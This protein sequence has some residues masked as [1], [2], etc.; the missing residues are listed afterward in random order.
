MGSIL[1]LSGSGEHR[2]H[3][4]LGL[5]AGDAG[6]RHLAGRR[7]ARRLPD[8]HLPE[9]VRQR[10][11]S[12]PRW[13][14]PDC[15][16]VHLP[17]KVRGTLAGARARKSGTRDR[18][19][20]DSRRQV[21]TPLTPR[22]R[23]IQLPK[24]KGQVRQALHRGDGERMARQTGLRY[25]LLQDERLSP[26][27]LVDASEHRVDVLSESLERHRLACGIQ[28]GAEQSLKLGLHRLLIDILAVV[29]HGHLFVELDE[30]TLLQKPVLVEILKIEKLCDHLIKAPVQLT[31][32][33]KAL[34][35]RTPMLVQDLLEVGRTHRTE[36]YAKRSQESVA[37]GGKNPTSLP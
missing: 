3:G 36:T 26:L 16:P 10:Q 37:E 32:T 20:T 9:L 6:P 23:R 25:P 11:A 14:Q 4:L 5:K 19:C 13:Q 12:G 29:Q 2:H 18:W 8:G 15:L 1:K 17:E 7:G 30:L 21:G 34:A 31:L 35:V 33:H 27:V 28:A 22:C 24:Q